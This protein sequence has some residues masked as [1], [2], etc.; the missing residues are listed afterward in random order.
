M[1]T[2]TSTIEND[3]TAQGEGNME[4]ETFQIILALSNERFQL[5]LLAGHQRLMPDE[6]ARLDQ[7]TGRL[8]VLW[9][10]Y[11][12]ELAADSQESR[13]RL[14][15]QTRHQAKEIRRVAMDEER[16]AA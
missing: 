9:D 15:A 10:Q 12:R 5:Y 3:Q 1:Q 11:R 6:I 4:N 14:L 7:I 2:I 16:R 13:E 8:S